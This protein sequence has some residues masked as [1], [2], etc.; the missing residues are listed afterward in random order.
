MA[1]RLEALSRVFTFK[2][3]R[4]EDVPNYRG[5]RYDF[6]TFFARHTIPPGEELERELARLRVRRDLGEFDAHVRNL[7]EPSL[8]LPLVTLWLVMLSADVDEQTA[9]DLLIAE[10]VRVL[11]LTLAAWKAT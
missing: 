6:E 3:V 7:P 5:L 11:E 1:M 9:R 10:P 2:P 8:L 4:R